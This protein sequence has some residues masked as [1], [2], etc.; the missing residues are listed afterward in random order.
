MMKRIEIFGV[1]ILASDIKFITF[2]SDM[3][4]KRKDFHVEITYYHEYYH[5]L[6]YDA[7]CMGILEDILGVLAPLLQPSE[8]AYIKELYIKDRYSESSVRIHT[9]LLDDLLYDVRENERR[10]QVI[11]DAI[12]SL[13]NEM[14]ISDNSEE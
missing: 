8:I 14:N 3:D 1:S 13:K 4:G 11:E 2:Y 5:T 9:G 12:H 6:K 10:R 7:P